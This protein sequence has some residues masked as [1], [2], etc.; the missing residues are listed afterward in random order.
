MRFHTATPTRC[1]PSG[2]VT[3][4]VAN[5]GPPHEPAPGQPSPHGVGELEL[6]G[7]QRPPAR[8]AAWAVSMSAAAQRPHIEQGR[9][10]RFELALHLGDVLD[11]VVPIVQ[12]NR[13]RPAVHPAAQPARTA[14]CWIATHRWSSTWVTRH[15]K[16]GRLNSGA[17]ATASHRGGC[18]KPDAGGRAD[19][20]L[21]PLDHRDPV[22][23][24]LRPGVGTAAGRGTGVRSRSWSPIGST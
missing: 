14:S 7:V 18:E 2:A 9:H 4:A 8:W 21:H 12:A 13:R 20:R 24:P 6:V 3:A 1:T 10:G 15:R 11:G 19:G 17:C 22:R 16:P 5:P 23:S